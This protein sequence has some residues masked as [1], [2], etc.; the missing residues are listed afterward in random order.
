MSYGTKA[1][2]RIKADPSKMWARGISVDDL[3]AA[4]RN[5]TSYAGAG[6][7]D[8]SAGT[9]LAPPAGPTGKC[10][11]VWQPD[12]APR[13]GAPVYLRDVA[14][15]RIQSRT[16]GSTCDSGLRVLPVPSATV[17]VAVFRQAGCQRGG[18][19]EERTRFAAGDQR[20]TPGVSSAS[21]RFTIVRGPSSTASRT[22]RRRS[23]SR[24]SWWCS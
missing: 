10:P 4:I 16:N 12:R 17:V 23:S 3:A 1:A 21:R 7:F 11:G 9:V 8:G 5:G 14:G 20:R 19:G 18:S 15:L 2:V 13:N 6:Q 24:S 22:C